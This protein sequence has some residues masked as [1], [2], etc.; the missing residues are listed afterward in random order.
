MSDIGSD[1]FGEEE[2]GPYLGVNT[3]YYINN[4]SHLLILNY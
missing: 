2:T 4:Y 1:E 3:Q